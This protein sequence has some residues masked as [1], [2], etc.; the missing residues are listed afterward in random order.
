MCSPRKRTHGD[1]SPSLMCTSMYTSTVYVNPVCIYCVCIHVRDELLVLSYTLRTQPCTPS[2][3]YVQLA[4]H[5]YTQ[6]S[7]CTHKRLYVHAHTSTCTHR[8]LHVHLDGIYTQMY[9]QTSMCAQRTFICT[10][11]PPCLHPKVHTGAHTRR[12][13]Q[14]NVCVE[15]LACV[16]DKMAVQET[17]KM[18]VGRPCLAAEGH[19][20]RP[21]HRAEE[22]SERG[23]EVNR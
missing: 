16:H 5:L 11:R 18:P 3:M 22:G 2:S 21:S 1:F 17:P 15:T 10:H 23:C 4:V 19:A 6:T 8:Y 14:L 13:V 12:H 9:T 7:I 20:T